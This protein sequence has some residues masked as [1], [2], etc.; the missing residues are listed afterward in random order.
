MMT[1]G[2]FAALVD[3]AAVRP[4]AALELKIAPLP[5]AEADRPL[6]GASLALSGA[7]SRS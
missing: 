4:S 1:H 5:A 3:L 2:D 6:A 7:S